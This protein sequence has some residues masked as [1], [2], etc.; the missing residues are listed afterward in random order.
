MPIIERARLRDDIDVGLHRF[1]STPAAHRV[2]QIA[3]TI[4][5]NKGKLLATIFL[6]AALAK[7]YAN[8]QLHGP[9]YGDFAQLGSLLLDVEQV[10]GQNE[11]NAL[12]VWSHN[13]LFASGIGGAGAAIGEIMGSPD[14][15]RGKAENPYRYMSLLL[16]KT[17][18]EKIG[19]HHGE[20]YQEL[21]R[22]FTLRPEIH[23]KVTRIWGP[24]CEIG[25][26]E[27]APVPSGGFLKSRLLTRYF[28][29]NTPNDTEFLH[30]TVKAERTR[31]TISVIM[32]KDRM[33][34][35]E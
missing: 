32:S 23:R 16:D 15:M 25:V 4:G 24:I 5:Q 26:P 35:K 27:E 28:R 9:E 22:L 2:E 7:T 8:L 31:A 19:T 10:P 17:N 30:E 18:K 20:F 21:Y 11:L 13:A 6:A 33:S 14:I 3:G 1:L 12:L 29:H 34:K